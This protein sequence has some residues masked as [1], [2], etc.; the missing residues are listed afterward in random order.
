M[1]NLLIL[2]FLITILL[3]CNTKEKHKEET[4]SKTESKQTI[5]YGG[6]IITMDGDTPQYVEAVIVTR[7]Y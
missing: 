2:V 5:Y 7:I 6:D 1:K 3:S 4:S